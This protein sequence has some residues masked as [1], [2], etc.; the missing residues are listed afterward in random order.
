MRDG[1]NVIIKLA[2]VGSIVIGLTIIGAIGFT[3][4]EIYTHFIR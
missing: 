2:I 1:I 4:Y 3:G